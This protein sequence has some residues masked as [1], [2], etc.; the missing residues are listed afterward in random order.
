MCV[1]AMMEVPVDA[2][3]V[4]GFHPLT[5]NEFKG[6]DARGEEWKPHER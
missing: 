3:R 2:A 1:Q 6:G 5:D 4:L